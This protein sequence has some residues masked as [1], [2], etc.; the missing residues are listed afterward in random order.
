MQA[1]ADPEV[2]RPSH[3]KLAIGPAK[4]NRKESPMRHRFTRVCYALAAA[5]AVTATLGLSAMSAASASTHA[6]KPHAVKP[7]ATPS[8]GF[9]CFNLFSE[10]YGFAQVQKSYK[11][12]STAGN[13]LILAQ[14]SNSGPGEDFVANDV[15]SVTTMCAN[16]PDPGSLSPNSDACLNY[17]A[18]AG[19]F[20]VIEGNYSPLGAPTNLCAG[21]AADAFTGEHVTL[22][23][24]GDPRTEWIAD[25]DNFTLYFFG[26]GLVPWINASDTPSSHPEVLT[27]VQSGKTPKFPLVV[28][29]EQRFSSGTVIDAQ[30]WGVIPGELF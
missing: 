19:L 16:Y 7:N 13:P 1:V 6:V 27:V 14:A 29:Q 17:A 8:C 26:T 10:K 28:Q 11:A 18:P 4:S 12:R 15:G 3:R 2:D 9:S 25:T 21:L 22:Q 24:C 5:S 30:E 23:K 20:Q